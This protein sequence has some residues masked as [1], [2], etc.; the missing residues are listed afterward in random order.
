MIRKLIFVFA[1]FAS[2]FVVSLGIVAGFLAYK[3][4]LTQDRIY[5]VRDV[6]TGREQPL[7]EL[8]DPSQN[9]QPSTEDVIRMRTL[10]VLELT[11]REAELTKLKETVTRKADQLIADQSQFE[12]VQHKFEADL[13]ARVEAVSSEAT[14]QTRGILLAMPAEN[15]VQNLM[16]LDV[17]ENI[18]LLKGM[19][20]ESIAEILNAFLEDATPGPQNPVK[21]RGYEILKAIARGAPARTT[22]QETMERIAGE[23][24]PETK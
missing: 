17:D 13:A 10:R 24:P 9:D 3:G 19:P 6:F 4:L 22:L 8:E 5:Q 20:E 11:A 1:A 16:Q 12:K 15:A 23:P 21:E 7:V 14:E 2:A 18:V